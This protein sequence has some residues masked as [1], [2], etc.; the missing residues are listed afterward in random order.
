MSQFTT[1]VSLAGRSCPVV[2][3]YGEVVV[4]RVAGI[5]CELYAVREVG[6]KMPN[7]L[8]CP[9]CLSERDRAALVSQCVNDYRQ[10]IPAHRGLAEIGPEAP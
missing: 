6:A 9:G 2:V 8:D 3:T 7:L 5:T 10:A 4:D 1:C